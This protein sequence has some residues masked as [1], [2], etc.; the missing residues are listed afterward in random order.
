[1]TKSAS[2]F[3]AVPVRILALLVF[4]AALATALPRV[5]LLGSVLL[6]ALAIVVRV[7]HSAVS[8][9]RIV[10]LLRRVRWLLLAILILYGWF[11]PGTPVLPE[12]GA[13]SPTQEGLWQGLLRVAALCG[14]VA[15][16]YLLLATTARGELVSGLLWF[17][18]PLRRIGID[19]RRFAVRLVLALEAV[20]QVQDLARDALAQPG[21]GTRMQRLGK[22]AA[23]LLQATLARAEQAPGEIAAPDPQPVP[24]WQWL[25]PAALATLLVLA[26]HA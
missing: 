18:R 8:S 5:L 15:A 24:A 20:P 6:A 3:P 9:L 14:I 13:W 26:G 19:D 1:M 11:L 17:G 2:I 16:V 23:N 12:W 7:R 21:G 4:A 10:N 22:A 25:L